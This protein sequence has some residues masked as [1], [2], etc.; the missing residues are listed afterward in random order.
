MHY[1]F[2]TWDWQWL[3][4]IRFNGIGLFPSNRSRNASGSDCC[5]LTT[6]LTPLTDR[7]F[8]LLIPTSSVHV[9]RLIP[10][11]RFSVN[12]NSTYQCTVVS[13]T[14]TYV[15]HCISLYFT[16]LTSIWIDFISY[17]LILTGLTL[18]RWCVY[19]EAL[20]FNHIGEI[21][22]IQIDTKLVKLSQSRQTQNFSVIKS[23]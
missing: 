23:I 22:S 8:R 5:Y 1:H 3:V 14:Y 13:F 6:N 20:Y 17:V 7:V 2:R 9:S 16:G 11:A 18:F 10:K 4:I 19:L 12:V 15:N 21:R